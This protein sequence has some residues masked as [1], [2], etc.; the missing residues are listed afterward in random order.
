[1]TA[2]RE[3]VSPAVRIAMLTTAAQRLPTRVADPSTLRRAALLFDVQPDQRRCT[4]SKAP[5]ERERGPGRT[6]EPR[7]SVAPQR[8]RTSGYRQARS[9]S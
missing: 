4:Q 1:M 3:T 6:P 7:Q 8:T 9:S 2:E 5:P